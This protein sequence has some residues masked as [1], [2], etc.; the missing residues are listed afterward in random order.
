MEVTL[1]KRPNR[2]KAANFR[3]QFSYENAVL[4]ISFP[5]LEEFKISFELFFTT[6]S[7]KKI[8]KNSKNKSF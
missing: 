8:P 1:R 7:Q 3:G 6:F 5:L 4:L 2:Q